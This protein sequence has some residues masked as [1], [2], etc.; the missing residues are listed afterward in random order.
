MTM[1][2]AVRYL[3]AAMFL[4]VWLLVTMTLCAVSFFFQ[5]FPLLMVSMIVDLAGDDG[6]RLLPDK[7]IVEYWFDF[8]MWL[9]TRAHRS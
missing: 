6:D 2:A 1:G 3:L 9:T 8:T 7:L 4:P 5:L